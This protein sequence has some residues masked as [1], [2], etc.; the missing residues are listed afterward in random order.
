MLYPGGR[1]TWLRGCILQPWGR[2]AAVL[3]LHLWCWALSQS[4]KS[5]P[6]ACFLLNTQEHRGSSLVHAVPKPF[7]V[8]SPEPPCWERN[9]RLLSGA[10]FTEPPL[11][12]QAR[13]RMIMRMTVYQ[14]SSPAAAAHILHPSMSACLPTAWPQILPDQAQQ[15][16]QTGFQVK[17]QKCVLAVS[18]YYYPALPPPPCS[19]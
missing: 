17:N 18:S 2:H 7:W 8:R 5:S 19:N 3:T 16:G 1:K 4:S 9:A 11:W 13:T 6:T 14:Q 15:S 12:R 10:A